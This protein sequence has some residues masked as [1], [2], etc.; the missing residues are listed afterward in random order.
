MISNNMGIQSQSGA[1]GY[2]PT[3]GAGQTQ[4]VQQLMSTMEKERKMT[5]EKRR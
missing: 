2:A 3:Q 4:A 1:S 5:G